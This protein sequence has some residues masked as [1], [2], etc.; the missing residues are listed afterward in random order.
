MAARLRANSVQTKHAAAPRRAGYGY[1][2]ATIGPGPGP[3]RRP[4]STSTVL[5][6]RQ[7]ALPPISRT[8]VGCSK[9]MATLASSGCRRGLASSTLLFYQRVPR[10]NAR[11]NTCVFGNGPLLLKVAEHSMFRVPPNEVEYGAVDP[12]RRDRSK[13]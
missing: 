3:N 9:S 7:S 10:L 2:R 5:I 4:P 12:R 11:R 8:S 6:A 1:M 13:I